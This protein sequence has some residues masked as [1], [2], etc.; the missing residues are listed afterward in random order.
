MLPCDLDYGAPR[1]KAFDLNRAVD[2]GVLLSSPPRDT[3]EV[4][5]CR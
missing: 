1:V 5:S 2:V 4:V 3:P